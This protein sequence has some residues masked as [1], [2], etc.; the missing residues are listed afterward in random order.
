MK[1]QE[2]KR[3]SK[4]KVKTLFGHA[5]KISLRKKKIWVMAVGVPILAVV[6]FWGIAPILPVRDPFGH[7][8]KICRIDAYGA[9]K[10]DPIK[11]REAFV[12]AFADCAPGGTVVVPLGTWVTGGITI[13]SDITLYL[14]FGS[15]LSFSDDPN[16][17]LPAVATRWEGMDVINYQPLIYVPNARNVAILGNGKVYG[18]GEKWWEWK[19]RKGVDG[20]LNSAKKL[21]EMAENDTP[22]DERQFGSEKNHLRPSMIQTYESDNVVIDGPSFFDGPMWTIH[23]VYSKNVIVRNVTVDTVGPNTD[24]IA[25]D[26]S[27]DVLV[28][29]CTIGSGDDA[30][31]IKSG[32]DYD[33]WKQNRP[34]KHIVVENSRVV[35]G[36]GGVT[37][38]SEMSGGVEDVV[39]RGMRFTNVDT[40]I[41]LKTLKGRGGYIR[42][43]HYEDIDMQN[44][45][46]DAIQ[47]D[48]K[49]KYATLKSK[50][51]AM[52]A[53]ENISFK[54]IF[55]RKAHQAFRIGGMEEMPIKNITME[56]A[57]FSVDTP[58]R[59]NDISDSLFR[60]VSVS[61]K[62]RK[63]IE[64]K[65]VKN[66]TLSGYFPRGGRGDAFAK[67]QGTSVG[68]ITVQLFPCPRNTCVIWDA[69][70]PSGAVMFE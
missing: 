31:V 36:N 26:S 35:R 27:E 12:E 67:L 39:V 21:Y 48:L 44:I 18:N 3:R 17:Y 6:W 2:V 19:Q 41:R 49:Y 58:G 46:E 16:L 47:L 25:I 57:S 37:I 30:I 55:V 15:T 61:A 43:I 64:M 32:L 62:N 4:D 45:V 8:A 28:S 40:G 53:V 11:T 7:T 38:G 23:F 13:P 10:T 20:E 54:N 14:N 5:Q 65:N 34:S 1:L 70:V 52:P 29:E 33:G 68:N 60:N 42:D 9:S 63:S 66:T 51:E 69:K 24:G 59:A 50:S 56:R 22:L